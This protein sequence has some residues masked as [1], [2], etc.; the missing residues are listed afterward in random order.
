MTQIS[1]NDLKDKMPDHIAEFF[2]VFIAG[3]FEDWRCI[4]RI[5]TLASD[6]EIIRGFK[7]KSWQRYKFNI[8]KWTFIY[9]TI[10]GSKLIEII[11]N[12]K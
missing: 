6:Y 1:H 2:D 3:F 4:F 10:P 5:F 9:N 12:E 8:D 11:E 7:D